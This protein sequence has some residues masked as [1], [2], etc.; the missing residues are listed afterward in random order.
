MNH[1]ND[2]FII[3]NMLTTVRMWVCTYSMFFLAPLRRK[4]YF[5]PSTVVVLR[6]VKRYC[7]AK[8]NRGPIWDQ[9]ERSSFRIELLMFYFKFKGNLLFKLQEIGFSSLSQNLWLIH[10]NVNN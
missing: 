5:L 3:H 4:Q 6:K 8:I 10:F 9:I 1:K 2:R 7:P